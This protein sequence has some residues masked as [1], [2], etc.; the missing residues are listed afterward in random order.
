MKLVRFGALGDERPGI[1]G[2]MGTVRDVSS[3]VRDWSGDALTSSILSTISRS[4][5]LQLPAAPTDARLGCPI[6]AP[7]KIVCVGLNYSGHAVET[8]SELPAEPLIFSSRRPHYLD[9]LI[10]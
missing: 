1:R 5:I 7:G 2:H 6:A 8:G 10:R 3:L 9:L 4:D